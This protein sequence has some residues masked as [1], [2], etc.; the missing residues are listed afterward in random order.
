MTGQYKAQ[1]GQDLIA[2][3]A[4]DGRQAVRLVRERAGEFGV[5]GTGW[6]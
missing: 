1:A 4:D 2:L 3:A 6:A 5:S